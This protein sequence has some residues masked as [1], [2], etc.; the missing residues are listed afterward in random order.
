MGDTRPAMSQAN[1]DRFLEATE[2]FNRLGESVASP[3]PEDVLGFVRLMDPEVQFEPQ[4]TLLEGSYTGH[5][6]VL[7]WLIDIAEHY[8]N[9]RM[10]LSDIRDLG[11]R[12]LALGTLH[13]TGLGSGIEIEVPATIVA[14][15][16]DGLMTHLKDYG[17]KDRALEAAG[18]RE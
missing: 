8:D 11:D 12:V 9:G 13:V 2:L 4:Q 14:S 6:G 1:V 10:H 7:S 18:L 3:N 16:R 5:G 15:F 17:D